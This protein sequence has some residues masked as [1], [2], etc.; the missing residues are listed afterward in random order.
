METEAEAEAVVA[1]TMG[2]AEVAEMV[3]MVMEAAE[4]V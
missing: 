1:V 2:M 4:M 3:T